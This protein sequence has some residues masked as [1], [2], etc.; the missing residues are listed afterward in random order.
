MTYATVMVGMALGEPNDAPLEVAAQLAER[1]GATVIGA[2]AAEFTP[3]V[4]FTAGEAAQLL[5]DQG[6]AAVKGRMVELEAE[7]RE[8]MQNR[9]TQVEWR[10]AEDFPTRYIVQQARA[11]DIV[12]VGEAGPGRIADPFVQADPNELVMQAGRPMLVVPGACNWLDLRSVLVAWKDTVEARRAI[13]GAL[14]LLRKAAEVTI[15]EIV[16]EAADRAAALS[17][18][19]DV[20]A[21][22][23]RHGVPASQQVPARC[24]DAAA[25]LERITSNVG[26]GVVIAG[27]Y[28]HSRLSEWML[29]GVTRRLINPSRHCSL[30]AH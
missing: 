7:F 10:S 2:A 24:G 11:C 17:R 30:L 27:A 13:S 21:W 14:P 20:A 22:L 19:A 18:I 29:G 12:V 23:S 8:A 5:V 6:W 9:A 25:Q 28:G 3:P 4:Y 1:F 16:E 26:A 15:V